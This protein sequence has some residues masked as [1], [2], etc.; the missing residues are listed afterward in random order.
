[1]KEKNDKGNSPEEETSLEDK[2][3]TIQD[4][5][6]EPNNESAEGNNNYLEDLQRLQAEFINFRKRTNQE[7]S[8][9][10]KSSN[11]KLILEIL[12]VLENLE[13]AIS[14]EPNNNSLKIVQRNLL[15]TLEKEGLK[16]IDT[17]G[18]FNP[19]LHEAIST[20]EGKEENEILEVYTEGYTLNEKL[21][22]PSIVKI[23]KLKEEE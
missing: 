9:L 15:Q 16:K 22:K 19:E 2:E 20:E 21:L 6:D 14:H 8:E 12:P 3:E 4:S 7:K 13:K 5:S 23:S 1:M 10:I 11:K 17:K 18:N